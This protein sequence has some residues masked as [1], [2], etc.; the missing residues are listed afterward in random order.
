V[1][2]QNDFQ[3]LAEIARNSGKAICE[4]AEDENLLMLLVAFYRKGADDNLYNRKQTNI[5]KMCWGFFWH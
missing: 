4:T 1:N 3:L 5:N 2:S